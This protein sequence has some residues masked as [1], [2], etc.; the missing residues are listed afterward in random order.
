VWLPFRSTI[1]FPIELLM[2]RLSA[3]EVLLGFSVGLGWIAALT[4]LYVTMWRPAARRHQA[5]AG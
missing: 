5:V 4:G 3:S 2:G 1:G